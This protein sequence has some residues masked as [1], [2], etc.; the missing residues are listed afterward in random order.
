MQRFSGLCVTAWID[1]TRALVVA[2]LQDVERGD[3]KPMLE[4]YRHFA[5]ELVKCN[6]TSL[7]EHVHRR[8]HARLVICS[9]AWLRCPIV[10]GG[11]CVL[12]RDGR[13]RPHLTSRCT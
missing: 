10:V 7:H 5:N 2:S 6:G 3:I 12:F 8:L 1:F 9:D 4:R 13:L 11:A